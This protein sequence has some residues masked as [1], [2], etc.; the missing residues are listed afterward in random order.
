MEDMIKAAKS[1]T[2]ITLYLE[3]DRPLK[4]EYAVAGAEAKYYLA[5]RIESA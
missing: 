5:P 1:E 3:N 4:M 2:E